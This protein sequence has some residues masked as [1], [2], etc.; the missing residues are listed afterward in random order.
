MCLKWPLFLYFVFPIKSLHERPNRE[1]VA[2]VPR[3]FSNTALTKTTLDSWITDYLFL[4]EFFHL[5][6]VCF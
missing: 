5:V 2:A 1:H 4:W 6:A 3:I